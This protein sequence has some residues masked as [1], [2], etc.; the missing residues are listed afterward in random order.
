[1]QPR[2]GAEL[3]C[4]HVAAVRMAG[5]LL[6]SCL[7]VASALGCSSNT[8]G[9]AHPDPSAA[10]S[11]QATSTAGTTT[12]SATPSSTAVADERLAALDP[13][14]W[15]S[16]R[17]AERLLGPEVRSGELFTGTDR[18]MC[19]WITLEWR[20]QVIHFLTPAARMPMPPDAKV[21]QVVVGR[22]QARRIERLDL[23]CTFELPMSPASVV[24]IGATL[25]PDG[26]KEEPCK[27]AESAVAIIEPRLPEARGG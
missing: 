2:A 4:R 17:E 27:L 23:Y 12:T 14:S 3:A 25:N 20:L 9:G 24:T 22:Y 18:P 26:S 16:D 5:A 19:Q 8:D 11:T 7:V 15:L 21:E 1:M 10:P 13:C 6:G